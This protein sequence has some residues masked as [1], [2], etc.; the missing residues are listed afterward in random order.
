MKG[1]AWLAFLMSAKI[2]K[3]HRATVYYIYKQNTLEPH[4]SFLTICAACFDIFQEAPL[5]VQS[6]R[7]P[8]DSSCICISAR[9]SVSLPESQGCAII[10]NQASFSCKVAMVT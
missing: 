5:M 10:V 1:W 7:L 2:S 6:L 4:C 8:P 9:S 3:K